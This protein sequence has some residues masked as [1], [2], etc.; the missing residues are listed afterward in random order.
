MG[1]LPDYGRGYAIMINSENSDALGRIS[2]LVRQYVIRDLTPPPLPPVASVP[3]ELQQHYTGYY[4]GV[5]PRIQLLYAFERLINIKQLAFT[6]NGLSTTTYGLHRERWVPM[7][8]RLFRRNEQS[9]ATVALLP[10]AD[11][12]TLIQSG[13]VTFKKVSALRIWGQF[14]AIAATVLFMLSSFL[15]ALVWVPRKLFGKLR[16]AGPLSVRVIPLFSAVL[17]IAFLVLFGTHIGDAQTL[18]VPNLL[19]IGIMLLSIAFPLTA[20]AGL[21]IAYRKRS[22]AMNRVAYW[23]S[24]LVAATMTGVAVYLGCWGLIGLRLWA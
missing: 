4:Q 2:T 1:Y 9:I 14:G 11:G 22:A 10:D 18:G 7:T 3:V 20:A 21:Y 19:S 17:L 12:D 15:F 6:T 8:E 23:H 16:N 24:V 5:S 13:Q